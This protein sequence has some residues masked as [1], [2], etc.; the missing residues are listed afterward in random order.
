MKEV[1][2]IIKKDLEK[3]IP[4][5]GKITFR[6]L[7]CNYIKVEGF[8]YTV[9]FR[10]ANY[11]S[12]TPVLSGMF[13][14]WLKNLSHRYGI[15]I[16]IGTRIG[17]GLVIAHFGGIVVNQNAVIGKNFYLRPNVVIG[18]GKNGE[19]PVFGD[20]VNVGAGAVIIGGIKVGNGVTIGAGSVVVHDVSEGV[21]VVG[22]PAKEVIHG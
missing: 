14:V 7:L 22:N 13:R 2:D 17:E 15:L 12:T 1:W 11:F 8:H 3:Y 10:L 6:L 20:S 19:C 4:A 5:S 16:P 9:I 21:T 18:A